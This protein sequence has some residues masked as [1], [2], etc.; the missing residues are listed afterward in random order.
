MPGEYNAMLGFRADLAKRTGEKF[1]ISGD[2]GLP[3]EV[4]WRT[5]GYVT[6]VKNQVRI[7]CLYKSTSFLFPRNNSSS[8]LCGSIF[9]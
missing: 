7:S 5:K 3:D 6:P 8:M 2:D 9:L 1:V 4:D